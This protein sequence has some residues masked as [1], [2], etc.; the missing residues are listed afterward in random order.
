VRIIK[1]SLT[2][3]SRIQT[4]FGIFGVQKVLI[5]RIERNKLIELGSPPFV[6]N[7]E[8]VALNLNNMGLKPR[9]FL[10]SHIQ[11]VSDLERHT[12]GPLFKNSH[13]IHRRCLSDVNP[14]IIF[15]APPGEMYLDRI[16]L[17]PHRYYLAVA[18]FVHRVFA[19][20][21]LTNLEL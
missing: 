12:S 11:S 21:M 18:P 19:V 17:W 9:T 4:D 2:I 10:V 13:I 7:L 15:V 5:R 8:E 3:G 16:L 14:F 6:M 20:D 1:L